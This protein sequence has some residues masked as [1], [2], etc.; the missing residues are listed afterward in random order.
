[1]KFRFTKTPEFVSFGF[2][3]RIINIDREMGVYQYIEPFSVRHIDKNELHSVSI[4]VV[5]HFEREDLVQLMDELWE[6]GIRPSNGEC[7]V[8]EIG[9]LKYHLE[10]MRKLIFKEKK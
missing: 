8:G 2:D 5:A 1:M 6:M 4:P 10:D 7:S 9:A 3:L